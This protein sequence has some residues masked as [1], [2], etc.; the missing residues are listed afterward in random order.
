VKPVGT[1]VPTTETVPKALSSA[2]PVASEGHVPLSNGIN[3]DTEIAV[4]KTQGSARG[5][6]LQLDIRFGVAAGFGGW[7][8]KH[9]CDSSRP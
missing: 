4:S 6:V 8:V 9:R 3:L 7:R 5:V 1:A 2:V